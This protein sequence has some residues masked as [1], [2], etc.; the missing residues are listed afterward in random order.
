MSV[1]TTE[2]GRKPLINKAFRQRRPAR[3]T[4]IEALQNQDE[5]TTAHRRNRIW[6]FIAEQGG[7][8][9][10]EVEQAFGALHQTISAAIS[11]LSAA[12][13]L[14]DTGKRRPTGS[15]RQAIV[16]GAVQ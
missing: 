15:G 16:W 4:S 5:E 12:G 10:W 13:L 2:G 7:A 9:C 11:S 6:H 1:G 8:T 14:V 3:D